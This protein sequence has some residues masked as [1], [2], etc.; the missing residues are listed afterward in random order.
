MSIFA[1][2]I[3]LLLVLAAGLGGFALKKKV[4]PVYSIIYRPVN[5]L[6]AGGSKV[7]SFFNVAVNVAGVLIVFGFYKFILGQSNAWSLIIAIIAMV[8]VSGFKEVGL[9]DYVQLDDIMA[10][11]AGIVLGAFTIRFLFW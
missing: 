3:T 2:V 5:I 6:W 1:W 11:S 9:D 10:C 4:E 7:H 8:G